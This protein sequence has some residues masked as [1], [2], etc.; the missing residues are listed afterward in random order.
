MTM[1]IFRA[2]GFDA[3]IGHRMKV[4]GELQLAANSILVVDGEVESSHVFC[5]LSPD[6]K[7]AQ[8]TTLVVNGAVEAPVNSKKSLIDVFNVT[9][10]GKVR[11][12]RLRVEGTLAVK[13]G[14]EVHADQIFYRE[15]IIENG[16]IVQGQMLHLD[17]SSEGEQV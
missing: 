9:V 13:V 16:A 17:H 15:L 12:H 6:N 10:T 3:L 8:K 7:V 14:A 5:E 11:C 2:R 1:K 4:T